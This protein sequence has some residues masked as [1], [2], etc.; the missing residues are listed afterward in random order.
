L[1]KKLDA[2]HAPKCESISE[3]ES[4]FNKDKNSS[5]EKVN[6]DEDPFLDW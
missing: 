5:A 6:K 2:P 4:T 3:K 1:L